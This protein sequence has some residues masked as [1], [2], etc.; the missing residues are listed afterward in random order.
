MSMATNVDPP[1]LFDVDPSP[2]LSMGERVRLQTMWGDESCVV[3]DVH[4]EDGFPMATVRTGSGD[5]ISV[6]V[7]RLCRDE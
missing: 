3:V 4:R 2:P 1:T 5:E 7:A 6:S